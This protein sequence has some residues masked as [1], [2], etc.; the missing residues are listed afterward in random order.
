MMK[1][2]KE[3]RS[4]MDRKERIGISDRGG[5]T[6]AKAARGFTLVE[7]LVVIAIVS[8]LISL[9]MPSVQSAMKSAESVKC[10]GN[11][12]ELG[13]ACLVYGTDNNGYL[14]W[15]TYRDYPGRPP[16]TADWIDWM[17]QLPQAGLIADQ[18]SYICPSDNHIRIRPVLGEPTQYS[19]GY[20]NILGNPEYDDYETANLHYIHAKRMPVM[21]LVSD[22]SDGATTGFSREF[23]ARLANANS[24]QT[25]F[26]EPDPT[27]I[28]HREGSNVFFMDGHAE[29][30]SWERAMFGYA[31]RTFNYTP[32]YKPFRYWW[33]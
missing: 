23:R 13:T 17:A 27:K 28:R 33:W 5:N 32:G 7:L 19:Y 31:S 12:R 15:S 9:L 4:G 2:L 30:V 24:P 26:P 6:R 21:P 22:A 25:Y 8:M 1:N 16:N 29:E 14:P 11:L 10:F 3:Q 18:S 20:N